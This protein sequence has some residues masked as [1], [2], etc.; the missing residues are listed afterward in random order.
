MINNITCNLEKLKRPGKQ[1]IRASQAGMGVDPEIN[2]CSAV[3]SLRAAGLQRVLI[4]F[5]STFSKLGDKMRFKEHIK[6]KNVQIYN[7]NVGGNGVCA[8]PTG[9]QYSQNS[10]CKAIIYDHLSNVITKLTAHPIIPSLVFPTIQPPASQ[11]PL[12]PLFQP[13]S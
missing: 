4:V 5:N 2:L 8:K 7:R 6:I 1:G 9:S 13:S 12:H 11:P 10:R 3:R